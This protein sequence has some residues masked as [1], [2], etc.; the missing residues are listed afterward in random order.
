VPQDEIGKP[1]MHILI[2]PSWY[3][4]PDRPGRGSFFKEQAEA[5][6][7]AE[8]RVGLLYAHL[9]P[10]NTPRLGPILRGFASTR[11]GPLTVYRWYG[12]NVPKMPRLNGQ[13]WV[14]RTRWLYRRYVTAHGQPDIIHAHSAVWAGVAAEAI[15]SE[16]GVPYVLTEHSTGFARGLYASWRRPLERA[17]RNARAVVAVGQ[18]LREQLARYRPRDDIEV[19]PNMV[20]VDLFMLPPGPRDESV[21][22]YVCIGYLQPRKGVD[23]LLH[24]FERAFRGIPGVSLHIG[25]DGPERR[26]L[27]ALAQSLDID[28]QVVFHGLLDR[29][30]VRDLL[31]SAHCCV[32]SSRIETFGIN[33]V[34]ALSTG[35]P[36]V[37]TRSGGPEDFIG[38][39]LGELVPPDDPTA[40]AAGMQ[41]V[42]AARAF[43][44]T[45]TDWLHRMVLDAFGKRSVVSRL[46][47]LYKRVGVMPARIAEARE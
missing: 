47:A 28:R 12:L 46:E 23:V 27:E 38:P 36:V 6:A 39:E 31:W 34:E 18:A 1:H 8:H 20:D 33:L 24:A 15:S 35:I 3:P 22:R 40:L 16:T 10:L 19:I 30:G 41:K 14:A 9:R 32:S 21:F 11:E 37:A 29:Q 43:W 7:A 13:R 5:L 42:R 44:G 4:T 2:L 25:G 26:K 17:F 45:R